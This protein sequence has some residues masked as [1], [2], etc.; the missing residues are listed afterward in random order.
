MKYNLAVV[1]GSRPDIIRSSIILKKL[2]NHP[3]INLTWIWTG[4]HYDDNLKGNFLK[5]LSLFKPDV[6]LDAT[7]SHCE[8]H[9]KLIKQL[10]EYFETNRPDACMF[11]G[12]T[13]AVIGCIVPLKMGIP[14][15]H[16]EAGM[17]SHDMRMPEERNRIVIDR[18]SDV[19]YAYQNDYKC[20][21]VQEGICPTKIVVT[22]NT[23][24]DV[25][26][27]HIDKICE[28]TPAVLSKFGV[29][30]KKYGIMTLHRD[31]HM[32]ELEADR[33]LSKVHYWAVFKGIKIILPVMPRLR[34]ILD[35]IKREWPSFILA[36]PLGFFDFVA[37]ERGAAIEFTDS[38]TNQETS[39]ILGVPCVVIRRSTERPETFDSGITVMTEYNICSAADH[40][41]KKNK[42]LNFT[43]GKGNAAEI[44]V[45][46]LVDR[47]KHNFYRE[48][49]TVDAFKARNWKTF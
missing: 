3:D 14:I 20:K 7:G 15:I 13:N 11:L 21:L 16:C 8:Q 44:I 48:D 39:A 46:D 41:I 5:E 2:R 40:I 22:G 33:I 24:V 25:L 47:L 38:G 37:L 23:I 9:W 1:L 43:L 35:K 17:R 10:S 18:I 19:L 42:S 31:E 12:D 45:T 36:E 26:N 29:E 27:E 49:P 28:I 32:D 6:E 4:Q 34:K 30:E